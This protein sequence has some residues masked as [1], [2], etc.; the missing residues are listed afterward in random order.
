LTKLSYLLGKGLPP[1]QCRELVRQ[2]LRGELTIVTKK[3]RFSYRLKTH[4]LIHSLISSL[5]GGASQA[6]PLG[7]TDLSSLTDASAADKILAPL[8][9]CNA[10]RTGDM[11]ALRL[12]SEEFGE[13]ISL[14][15][16]DKRTP[17]HIAASENQL[18]AVHLVRNFLRGPITS[19]LF[20]PRF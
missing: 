6:L 3:P 8:L 1:D 10:C 18:P 9:L 12:L 19:H 14:G 15:D 13:Y 16:Y 4:G 2:N 20:R 7:N 17:L 5:D 11:G